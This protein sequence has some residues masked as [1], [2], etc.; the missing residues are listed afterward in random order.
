[1]PRMFGKPAIR[2][3]RTVALA[4][5]AD[6]GSNC[7]Q[8]SR[9]DVDPLSEH[10]ANGVEGIGY[11][12]GP[13]TRVPQVHP[14]L[15]VQQP[16]QIRRDVSDAG[17]ATSNKAFT[18]VGVEED[19]AVRVIHVVGVRTIGLPV[20][21]RWGA[22]GGPFGSRC[23]SD[24]TRKQE[25]RWSPSTEARSIPS[26]ERMRPCDFGY[27]FA[28]DGLPGQVV[29]RDGALGD[30]ECSGR[31]GHSSWQEVRNG[32]RNTARPRN[33]SRVTPWPSWLSRGRCAI[34]GG[35]G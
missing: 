24:A 15:T 2:R 1:M 28:D 25:W 21:P 35:T 9:G 27:P 14:A 6:R 17:H 13:A 23:R 5:R 3:F 18:Q 10:P 32:T 16:L 11:R 30:E 33:W 19:E 8:P 31:I 34:A 29:S 4:P 26:T 12:P 22:L 20:D 7:H